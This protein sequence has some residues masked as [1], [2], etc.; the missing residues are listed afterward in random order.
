M[1]LLVNVEIFV[2]KKLKTILLILCQRMSVFSIL[3]WLTPEDFTC[4]CGSIGRQAVK[5]SI[6][7]WLTPEDFTS[8]FGSIR[9]S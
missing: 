1:I 3:L 8:Q 4:Q 7:L 5:N 9:H 2:D 6:L